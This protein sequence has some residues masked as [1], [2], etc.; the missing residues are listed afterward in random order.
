MVEPKKIEAPKRET[1]PKGKKVTKKPTTGKQGT[2]LGFFNK[3]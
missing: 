3:K 1:S 2:L